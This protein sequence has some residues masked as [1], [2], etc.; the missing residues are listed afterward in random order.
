MLY[1]IAPYLT[2]VWGPFR[3]FSSHLMLLAAG[4]LTGGLVIWSF[5]PRLWNRLP[6]DR[7][8]ILAAD[9]GGVSLSGQSSKASALITRMK[10]CK[11]LS[12]AQ[13]QGIIQPDADTGKERFSLRAQLRKEAA[14]AP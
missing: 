1:W 5:L 14:D 7:G 2:E 9:G 4:A 10:D 12:D 11:T 8:K 3:L 6:T 13:F